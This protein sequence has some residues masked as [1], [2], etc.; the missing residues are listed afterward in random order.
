MDSNELYKQSLRVLHEAH[1]V[2]DKILDIHSH[3]VEL[4]SHQVKVNKIVMNRL[5]NLS[6]NMKLLKNNN[7]QFKQKDSLN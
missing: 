6:K 3:Q 5:D 2:L 4:N 7:D 1:L